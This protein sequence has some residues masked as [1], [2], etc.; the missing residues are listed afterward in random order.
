MTSKFII[1]ESAIVRE[2]Y[3]SNWFVS[4]NMLLTYVII[5]STLVALM[6]WPRKKNPL[7]IVHV[8]GNKSGKKRNGRKRGKGNKGKAKQ[9]KGN[10]FDFLN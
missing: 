3:R 10:I 5:K 7:K 2:V 4:I 6:S 1:I 9:N 8:S